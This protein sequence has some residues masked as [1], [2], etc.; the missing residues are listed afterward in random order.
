MKYG[1]RHRIYTERIPVARDLYNMR[2]KRRRKGNRRNSAAA[3][4]CLRLHRHS[5]RSASSNDV[6]ALPFAH[7]PNNQTYPLPPQVFNAVRLLSLLLPSHLCCRDSSLLLE[8]TGSDIHWSRGCWARLFV[9]I[10]LTDSVVR[11]SVDLK[12]AVYTLLVFLLCFFFFCYLC[13]VGEVFQ[14][15]LVIRLRV[16]CWRLL[17]VMQSGLRSTY[18]R[19]FHLLCSSC[20]HSLQIVA[21]WKFYCLPGIELVQM[22]SL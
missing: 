17:V 1:I 3:P 22:L 9:S 8:S 13:V 12:R 4:I 11:G 15:R 10:S 16:C 6:F 7:S 20:P 14:Q 19:N 18:I 21:P 5:S 2:V